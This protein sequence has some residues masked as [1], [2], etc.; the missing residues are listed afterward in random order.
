MHDFWIKRSSTAEIWIITDLNSSKYYLSFSNTSQALLH[1]DLAGGGG[2]LTPQNVGAWQTRRG[3]DMFPRQFIC[4]LEVEIKPCATGGIW[5]FYLLHASTQF[6]LE[7]GGVEP[8]TFYTLAIPLAV[9]RTNTK[10]T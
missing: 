3:L 8:P 2:G 9:A 5:V 4:I 7:G 1:G 6:N 10:Q